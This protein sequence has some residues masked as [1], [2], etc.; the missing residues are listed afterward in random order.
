MC[1]DLTF[2]TFRLPILL[3]IHSRIDQQAIFIIEKKFIIFW[4]LEIMT[5]NEEEVTPEQTD[6]IVQYSQITGHEDLDKCKDHLKVKYS[7][8]LISTDFFSSK[9]TLI[10]KHSKFIQLRLLLLNRT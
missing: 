1:T 4:V 10:L 3:L 6:L 5:E 2:L 9:M 7:L 8:F